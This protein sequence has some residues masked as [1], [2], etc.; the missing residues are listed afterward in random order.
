MEVGDRLTIN[1]ENYG[2]GTIRTYASDLGFAN[3]R[4]YKV[5]RNR[6]DRT[7]EI[8]REQ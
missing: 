7:Y 1:I 8:T 3:K 6:I 5:R 4:I 2:F